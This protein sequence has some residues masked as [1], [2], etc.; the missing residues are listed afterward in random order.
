MQNGDCVYG[1][2][3][4]SLHPGS[5]G[6]SW[7]SCKQLYLI[8]S[9]PMEI[10]QSSRAVL[11]C[12]YNSVT[13]QQ[14]PH[15]LHSAR[16]T[17]LREDTVRQESTLCYCVHHAARHVRDI[18]NSSSWAA[19]AVVPVT[20]TVP[21]VPCWSRSSSMSQSEASNQLGTH[22]RGQGGHLWSL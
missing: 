9:R 7:Y 19:W 17:Q 16:L 13:A 4:F 6:H 11:G 22:S 8:V 14:V 21:C 20:H 2:N 5:L 3:W 1:N 18:F 10:A 12:H 15:M